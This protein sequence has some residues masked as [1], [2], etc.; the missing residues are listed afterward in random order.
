L[1]NHR[2]DQA[3]MET[4]DRVFWFQLQ[5]MAFANI[6]T[7]GERGPAVH[8]QNLAMIPE[9][10]VNRERSRGWQ[11]ARCIVSGWSSPADHIWPTVVGAEIVNEDTDLNISLLRFEQ[12][13]QESISR[14]IGVKDVT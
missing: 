9:I 13:F 10:G 12:S 4:L 5:P 11:E 1:Q 6:R 14:A 8:N 3:K 7:A 2:P